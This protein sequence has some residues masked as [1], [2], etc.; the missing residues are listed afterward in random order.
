M[1]GTSRFVRQTR[2]LEQAETKR[3]EAS[4]LMGWM[5]RFNGVATKYLG[6]YLA[7]RRLLDREGEHATAEVCLAAAEVFHP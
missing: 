6:S 2:R 7:W 1:G 3:A 4:L 5:A